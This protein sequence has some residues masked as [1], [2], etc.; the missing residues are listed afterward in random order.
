MGG[1]SD[2]DTH[3]AYLEQMKAEGAERDDDSES[4]EDESDESFNP[5]SGG[6]RSEFEG[7][8]REQP[9]FFRKRRGI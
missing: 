5:E 9:V 7:R 2:E 6:E 8:V 3:D 1:G 4:S